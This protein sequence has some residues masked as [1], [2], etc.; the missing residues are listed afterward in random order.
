MV[1]LIGKVILY[2]EFLNM[3]TN[4]PFYKI[5]CLLILACAAFVNKGYGQSY[6]LGFS[7]HEVFQDKRT[8][9]DLSPGK[10][11]Y[12]KD[13]FELSFDLSLF[14]N[15][16]VYFGY[17]FRIVEDDK[18][19]IDLVHNMIPYKH[20]SV[21]VGDHLSKISFVVDSN[22]V[23]KDWNTFRIR[24]DFDNDRLM[25]YTGNRTYIENN[26][27]LKRNAGYKILFGTNNY[28]QFQTTDIPPMKLRDIRI[29]QNKT[30]VYNWPL[31]EESGNIAHEVIAQS[32]A[33]VINPTWISSM[34]CNWQHA[35]SLTVNGIA[36]VAFDAK[37]EVLHIVAND[38]VYNY[39][40]NNSKWANTQS[41]GGII[42]NQ[43]NQSVYNPFDNSLYN[44]FYDQRFVAK[45]NFDKQEWSKKIGTQPVTRY[46]HLNKM[47]SAADTSLYLFG[48]YGYLLYKNNV[49][50]YNFN[51]H[52]WKEIQ[53]KGDFFM[54][55]Y[56]AALGSTSKGDTAYIIGGYGNS[57]GQQILNPKNIYDM[58]RFTV[59][60]KTFKKIFELKVDGEDF[61]FANS[62]VIDDKAKT[63]YGLVFPQHKYNSTLQLISGSLN[64]PSYKLLANAIPFN[65][66]DTHSFADLY[67]CPDSKV[68]VAV[69]LLRTD[70]NQTN[71]NIYTL[72]SP[73][74]AIQEKVAAAK[75]NGYLYLIVSVLALL[76]FAGLYLVW[77]K[78]RQ[79]KTVQPPQ[80]ITPLQPLTA[81]PV[82]QPEYAENGTGEMRASK[83][84]NILK[85]SILLFGDLQVFD[86]EGTDI[87]KYFTPLI[88]ELFL[89]ILL[90]SIRKGRGL[91]SEKLNEILWA[92]KSAKSARNNRSV[93]IAKLKALL[94]KLGHCNLSKDTGYWKIDID[95]NHIYVDY[96]DYLNIVKDKRQLDKHKIK[97]LSDITQ[98]G[99]FLSNIE[100]EW[101]DTFKS[102]IS[103]EVIDTY[104]HFAN[105]PEHTHDAEFLIELANYI[106][107]FDPVNEEATILKCKALSTLGKHSLAKH[108]FEN[109]IKEYKTIYDED[110][111]KDFHAILE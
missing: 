35:Q 40:V 56:L 103:N 34:H 81:E 37:N 65:F 3:R 18:R 9:L 97:C 68:F 8:S 91:S 60:D 50:Q 83:P 52:I 15:R 54:P 14:A 23:Y 95:Y 79:V 21:I 94:D 19:N 7:S 41:N 99:N 36:S 90:Y 82:R 69:T 58:M 42:L 107:Y 101:L 84:A 2:S 67:Y 31:N 17:V 62:L 49:Q 24:F 76:A 46:W 93:N 89:V 51:S 29:T 102:E 47:V 73:P 44:L 71:V 43:G 1:L 72:L 92:D 57:S 85:N 45:F 27:H 87:T 25:F 53:P 26:V 28:L 11:L 30:I 59:K 55:R 70:N 98:R 109:F 6:G 10:Q 77:N 110:F 88:K 48:G 64:N 22:K 38:S 39:T 4:Y 32:D 13:N 104:L 108:T 63:Y 16:P 100:Y 5:F 33:T 61:T 75:N 80:T 78:N 105:S 96:Y 20:F 66:H 111:K 74:Y 86:S 12:F 106:F